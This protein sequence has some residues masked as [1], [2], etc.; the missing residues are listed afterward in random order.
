MSGVGSVG[1]RKHRRVEAEDSAESRPS[2]LTK[3]V[4]A[5]HA[6]LLLFFISLVSESALPTASQEGSPPNISVAVIIDN[7]S[8]MKDTDPKGLRFT[9]AQQFIDLLEKGDEVAL[10]LFSDG[11]QLLGPSHHLC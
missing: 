5:L 4:C 3:L 7:S 1:I 9:A 11:T 6:G 2:S 10:L 8:S